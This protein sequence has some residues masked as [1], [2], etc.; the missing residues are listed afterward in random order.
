MVSKNTTPAQKNYYWN[1]QKL[2]T[3]VWSMNRLRSYL[4]GIR[5][6]VVTDCQTI[7]HLNTQKTIHP[8]ITGW[9]TLL[10]EFDFEIKH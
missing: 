3:V 7:V 5:F 8:Q 4:I 2:M 9:V 6:L 10:S 1:K